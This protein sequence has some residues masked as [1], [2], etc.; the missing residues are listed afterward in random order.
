VT[1]DTISDPIERIVADGLTAAGI[2]WERGSPH[3]LD[4]YIPDFG[5]YIE[6]KQFATER[7]FKQIEPYSNVVLIQGREA[8]RALVRLL[9]RAASP[10]AALAAAE[11][12]ERLVTEA[13]DVLHHDR[14]E[15]SEPVKY[16]REVL[17]RRF[18]AILSPSHVETAE[19]GRG[20]I[21]AAV[22]TLAT[23]IV[24]KHANDRHPILEHIAQEIEVAFD[25][26]DF[27]RPTERDK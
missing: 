14:S 2:R 27:D 7:T 13:L 1:A 8:A 25:R 12:V 26:G 6:V 23:R 17:T 20:K 15:G 21:I 11:R 24:R 9:A 22:A 19:T 3:L 18:A 16:N 10:T 5:F 4:F